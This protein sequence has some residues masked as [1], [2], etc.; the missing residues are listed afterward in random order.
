MT[1]SCDRMLNYLDP[2][3]S[4]SPHLSTADAA[5]ERF[6]ASMHNPRDAL[7]AKALITRYVQTIRSLLLGMAEPSSY[8]APIAWIETQQVLTAHYRDNGLNVACENIASGANGGLYAV[9]RIIGQRLA[10]GFAQQQ[11]DNAVN[12]FWNM[13]STEG[14]L[15][16]TRRYLEWHASLL[17]PELRDGAAA[18]VQAYLPQYLKAH[19]RIAYGLRYRP[20]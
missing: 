3:V 6:D 16:A 5:L 13:L 19:P 11:I 1:D 18:R 17:P 15:E 14:R 10:E 20:D 2:A 4:W 7:E 9:L 12:G 8:P